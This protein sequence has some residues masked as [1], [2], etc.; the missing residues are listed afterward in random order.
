MI[1]ALMSKYNN[2]KNSYY[3]DTVLAMADFISLFLDTGARRSGWRCSEPFNAANVPSTEHGRRSWIQWRTRRCAPGSARLPR[4]DHQQ[5]RHD[6]WTEVTR[7]REGQRQGA[8]SRQGTRQRLTAA[9][10]RPNPITFTLPN[11]QQHLHIDICV[12]YKLYTCSFEY[13]R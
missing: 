2:S 8:G 4:E 3:V 7:A 10:L 9:R 12:M 6:G 13:Q 1:I 5:H 11:Q